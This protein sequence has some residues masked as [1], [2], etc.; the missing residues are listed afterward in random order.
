[1]TTALGAEYYLTPEA[2]LEAERLSPE[3]HEYLAGVVYARSRTTVDRNR[4]AMNISTQL[5]TQLRGKLC[6]VFS[7]DVKVRIR[8]RDAE[9][10]YYPDATVDC[11]GAAGESLYAR[12]PRIIFEVMSRESERIDRGKSC[13][14]INR[15]R[16]SRLT[17]WSIS[18]RWR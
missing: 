18:F 12:E 2:Y 13:A 3:K 10:Y 4:I 6:E 17:S 5:A 16:R 8:T 14:I 9:F 15:S 1:M 7:P 11:G